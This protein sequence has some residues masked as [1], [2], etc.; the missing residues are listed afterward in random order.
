MRAAHLDFGIKYHENQVLSQPETWGSTSVLDTCG[1]LARQE[2]QCQAHHLVIP[3]ASGMAI[4]LQFYSPTPCTAFSPVAHH[5]LGTHVFC[6]PFYSQGH[7][8][9]LRVS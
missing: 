7:G 9:K 6:C 4:L 3:E 5:H 2:D 1:V 8:G